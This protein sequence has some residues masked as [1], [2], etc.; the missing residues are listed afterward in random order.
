MPPRRAALALI[1]GTL[2]GLAAGCIVVPAAPPP[3]AVY[4]PAVVA[5]PAYAPPPCR[6]F[7]VYNYWQCR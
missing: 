7:W 1:L 5:P 4:V 3:R 2:A 6:W